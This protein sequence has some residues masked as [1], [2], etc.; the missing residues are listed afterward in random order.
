MTRALLAATVLA[1]CSVAGA[2]AATQEIKV[3]S[4][5]VSTVKHDIGPKGASKGDKIT[6]K[7]RLLNAT[8]QF[9]KKKGALVGSDSGTMTFTGVHSANFHGKAILPGGTL[10]LSGAVYTTPQGMVVPVAGGTGK[11]AHVHG[12]LLVGSGKTRVPNT[13]RLTRP[14]GPLA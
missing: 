13:Y 7:D 1:T 12:S 10:I 5:T 3:I 11:F 9:G 14:S 8:S 2:S 4:V 6:F